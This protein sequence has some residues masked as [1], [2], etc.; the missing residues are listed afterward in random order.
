MLELG[1]N[2]INK[3]Q[4]LD[5]LPLL[6]EL[7]LGKNKIENIEN[8]AILSGTLNVLSLSANKINYMGPE[9]LS[10]KNLTYFQISENYIEK[11]QNLDH[12]T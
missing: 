1:A 9:L 6:N 10:L 8:L 12:L 11:I 2:K 5:Q 3:I 4:N 7:Y